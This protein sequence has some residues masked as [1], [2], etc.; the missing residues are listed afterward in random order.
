LSENIVDGVPEIWIVATG[1][2]PVGGGGVEL[3]EEP[4]VLLLQ[5]ARTASAVANKNVAENLVIF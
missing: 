4:S 2:V 5:P 3:L 1:A